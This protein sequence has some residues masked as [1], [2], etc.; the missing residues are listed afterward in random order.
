MPT[1]KAIITF[2]I[3]ILIPPLKYLLNNFHFPTL[4]ESSICMRGIRMNFRYS[5]TELG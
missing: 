5:H 4:S 2:S 1:R 3:I